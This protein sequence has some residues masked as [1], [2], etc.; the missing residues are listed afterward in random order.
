M[1]RNKSR[2]HAWTFFFFYF[3]SFN[4]VPGDR[5]PHLPKAKGKCKSS[6]CVLSLQ[7]YNSCLGSLFGGVSLV[8]CS[9]FLCL[10]SVPCVRP[11]ACACYLCSVQ[12]YVLVF[13]PVHV[14]VSV[15]VLVLVLVFV[16][17]LVFVRVYVLVL[18][19][20]CPYFFLVLLCPMYEGIGIKPIPFLVL[21][22]PSL[23]KTMECGC[24]L[25]HRK[26][27]DTF[28]EFLV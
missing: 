23:K 5:K 28:I 22:N 17:V 19:L 2:Y 14:P 20:L 16:P 24:L 7:E 27:I 21:G 15:Q 12:V 25:T 6:G 4:G 26:H 3:F 9:L 13:V 18:S 1:K 11:C 8:H 10:C